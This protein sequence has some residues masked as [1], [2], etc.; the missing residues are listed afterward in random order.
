MRV[1]GSLGDSVGFGMLE[2]HS[3][4]LALECMVGG[5]PAGL[6][7][8]VGLGDPAGPEVSLEDHKVWRQQRGTCCRHPL[9]A[10]A[11]MGLC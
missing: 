6:G 1:K 10:A 7:T 8:S 2:G 4:I 5:N 3:R 9:E 11:A